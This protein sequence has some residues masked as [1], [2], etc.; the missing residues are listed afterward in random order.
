MTLPDWLFQTTWIYHITAIDNLPGI[1]EAGQIFATNNRP[2]NHANIANRDI[3][4]RRAA[5]AVTLPPNGVLHDYVPFYFAPRSPMLCANHNRSFIGAKPQDEIV[6]LVTTAQHIHR[7][8]LPYVFYDQ[9]AITAIA[10]CYNDIKYLDKID[11]E[12]FFEPPLLDCYSKYW[13]YKDDSNHPKWA[14]R[15]E[16]RQAE[17]LIHQSLNWQHIELIGTMN[18][19]RTNQVRL[20]LEDFGDGTSVET[21]PNWYFRGFQW[22]FR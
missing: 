7:Q 18:E 13:Q 22:L 21:K 3:Q 10:A 20:I 19:E 15:P 9:H 1:L 4:D 8:G 11:W 16:I 2:G 12:L 5:K 14:K 17:F 6:H